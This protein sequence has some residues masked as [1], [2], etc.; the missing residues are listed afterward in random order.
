MGSGEKFQ[1]SLIKG[2][3]LAVYVG[4]FPHALSI[5]I[6]VLCFSIYIGIGKGYDENYD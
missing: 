3:G 5:T 4:T 2:L 1:V 6:T